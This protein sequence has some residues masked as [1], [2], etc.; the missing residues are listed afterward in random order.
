MKAEVLPE[1]EL[2]FGGAGRHIDIRY[3]LAS[4]GP[5]DR[6]SETR[7]SEITLGV[8][9]IQESTDGLRAWLD[10]CAIGIHAKESRLHHLFTGFP[11]FDT[12]RS[13]GSVLR[14]SDGLSKLIRTTALKETAALTSRSEIVDRAVAIFLEECS[15][16]VENH[17]VDVLI[18]APP[19]DLFDAMDPPA[20][21]SSG[22]RA[23]WMA[24]V[25]QAEDEPSVPAPSFHDLLKAR[26]MDLG[27]P[28]Q[29]VRPETYDPTKRRRQRKR[30]TVVRQLQDEATRAW[31]LHTALYYKAGGTPWRLPRQST[32]LST[33]FVGVSFYKTAAGDRLMTSMA[34]VFNELGDGVVVRGGKVKIDKDDRQPHLTREGIAQLIRGALATYRAEHKTLPARL[35]VHK[36]STFNSAEEA[37]AKPRKAR[38]SIG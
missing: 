24:S 9:G 17:K 34:Q 13:Y 22:S 36:T 8:V 20:Q 35:V 7:P 3:G 11:G 2:E 1:P 4:Y 38:R 16:L 27:V 12:D 37:G 33:C 15:N 25:E 26:G 5:F 10:A 6:T 31:N 14:S 30:R 18:V 19:A 21:Q 29:L 32:D 28:I 23:R